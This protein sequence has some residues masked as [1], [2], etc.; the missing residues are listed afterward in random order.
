MQVAK[1]IDDKGRQIAK[2][3]ACEGSVSWDVKSGQAYAWDVD[4]K[5]CIAEMRNARVIWVGAAGLRR[6]RM[7]RRSSNTALAGLLRI[8]ESQKMPR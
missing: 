8:I 5:T 2:P 6:S 3:K 1:L 7:L 4:G